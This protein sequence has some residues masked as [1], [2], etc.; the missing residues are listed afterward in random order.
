[1]AFC[2]VLEGGLSLLAHCSL[3]ILQ[4]LWA[5]PCWYSALVARGRLAG[6]QDTHRSCECRRQEKDSSKAETVSGPH[7][8]QWDKREREPRHLPVSFHWDCDAFHSRE[9]RGSEMTCHLLQA[10]HVSVAG[11]SISQGSFPSAGPFQLETLPA[12]CVCIHPCLFLVPVALFSPK[13]RVL[14]SPLPALR[15]PCLPWDKTSQPR[16]PAVGRTQLHAFS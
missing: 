14:E 10:T 7:P 15:K 11:L 16:N 1:M 3:K 12:S 8:H 9:S 5:D 6:A 4:G 2:A 13:S